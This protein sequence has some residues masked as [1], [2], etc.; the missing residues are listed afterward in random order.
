[1]A[2]DTKQV[3]CE[4]G[5]TCWQIVAE[6]LTNVQ[7]L[8]GK[9]LYKAKTGPWFPSSVTHEYLVRAVNII[10]LHRCY[11]SR[12]GL[13]Q[14]AGY[15]WEGEAFFTVAELKATLLGYGLVK[16]LESGNKATL[17][18]AMPAEDPSNLLY[19]LDMRFLR[20]HALRAL[21]WYHGLGAKDA[22]F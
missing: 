1:M 13:N 8:G 6:T 15:K 2:L 9:K 12:R 7:Q 20:V 19:I 17:I 11:V 21:L 22:S 3:E 16:K 5:V 14:L 4:F 18:A 10:R